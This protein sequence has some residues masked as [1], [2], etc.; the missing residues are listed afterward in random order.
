MVVNFIRIPLNSGED[1]L[2]QTGAEKFCKDKE[3]E[4]HLD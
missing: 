4:F 2:M 3:V 1:I